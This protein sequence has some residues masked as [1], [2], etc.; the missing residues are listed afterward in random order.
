MPTSGPGF[1]LTSGVPLPVSHFRC[2][3]SSAPLPVPHF[4][5]PLPAAL[6]NDEPH[7]ETDSDDVGA[8]ERE[9]FGGAPSETRLVPDRVD[10]GEV[11]LHRD[12]DEVVGGGHEEAPEER[13]RL[14]D[15][16]V[17]QTSAGENPCNQLRRHGS[18][19]TRVPGHFRSN[20]A[21]MARNPCL[22]V[23]E[24]TQNLLNV[25]PFQVG[26]EMARHPCLLILASG[27][28]MNTGI[29]KKRQRARWPGWTVEWTDVG[30]DGSRVEMD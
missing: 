21:A 26:L 16:Q 22:L 15:L 14:P 12:S 10:D 27:H 18:A 28:F 23:S 29:S 19:Q 8:N 17:Q 13:L 25:W 9:E 24:L 3:T 20:R 2:P 11:A 5:C 30:R 4:R 1:L 6:T 7:G